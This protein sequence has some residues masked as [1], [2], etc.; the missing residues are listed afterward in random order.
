MWIPR[1]RDEPDVVPGHARDRIEVDPKL[2]GMVEVV[3]ADRMRIEVDAA[4][5]GDPREARRIVQDDL[6][7]GPAG[8]ERQGRGPDEVGQVLGRALL[9]EGLSGGAVDE[10]LQRHRPVTGAA[11][12]PVGDR[13]VVVH[14]I[15]L[16]VAGR[17]EVDL[18]GVG[19]RHLVP[20][21][22]E[23]LLLRR[24]VATI[25]SR[26]RRPAAR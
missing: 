25:P 7:R 23:D 16:R 4:E 6:V 10:P 2:V 18:P 3:G 19:D 5:V 14:E 12:R 15:E 26:Q 9:E 17:R 24:H 21:D 1:E 20:V 8:R 11:Q 22:P 13:Q